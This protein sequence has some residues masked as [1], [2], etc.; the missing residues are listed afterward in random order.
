MKAIWSHAHQPSEFYAANLIHVLWMAN[1]VVFVV[2]ALYFRSSILVYVIYMR[3]FC[4]IVSLN[5]TW[6]YRYMNTLLITSVKTFKLR[7]GIPVQYLSIPSHVLI[8]EI[9]QKL[10]QPNI[11]NLT[12]GPG[13]LSSLF[14]EL[15]TMGNLFRSCSSY[16][17]WNRICGIFS[18]LNLN[19][20][21]FQTT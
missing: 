15:G 7:H 6:R 13:I 19:H 12:S 5:F 10:M 21:V 2:T 18:T 20:S 4:R 17:K 16:P 1:L 14:G 3:Y 9:Y 11:E 8:T